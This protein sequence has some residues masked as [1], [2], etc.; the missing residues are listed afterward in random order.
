MRI[1]IIAATAALSVFAGAAIANPGLDARKALMQDI[2]GNVKV[3]GGYMKGKN[4]ASAEDVSWLAG[5]IKEDA[6]RIADAFGDKIHVENADGLKTTASPAIWNDWDKFVMVA[7]ELGKTAGAL[8]T[9]A[10]GGDK[11]AIGAAFGAMTKTC[12]A[13]HKPFRVKKK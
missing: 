1:G 9:T 12:G 10:A 5:T 3:I 6:A 13:C 11:K 4:K 8:E 7:G 2:V